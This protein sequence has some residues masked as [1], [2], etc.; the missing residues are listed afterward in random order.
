MTFVDKGDRTPSEEDL[1]SRLIVV[2]LIELLGYFLAIFLIGSMLGP[3][4][5]DYISS[6]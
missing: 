2:T 3:S 5:L 1:P 4:L 6:S